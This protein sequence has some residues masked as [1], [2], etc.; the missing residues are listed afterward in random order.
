MKSKLLLVADFD[1]TIAK[2]FS[3]SPNGMNVRVAYDMA[4]KKVFG[5]PGFEY[6]HN[7]LGGLG[8]RE[9]GE[10]V[11]LLNSGLN[12]NSGD[13]KL[14]TQSLIDEKLAC[15]LSEITPEW[16]L[17]YPGV[18][19]FYKTSSE[20]GIPVTTAVVSSGHDAFV[21]KVFEVNNIP[22]P[23]IL[24]T[25]D[26]LL[27]RPEL[28]RPR[29]K[30]YTYQLAEAHRLWR[31]DL[32]DK[33]ITEAELTDRVA[34]DKSRMAY[35][36]DDP[37]KDGSLAANARI[38]FLYVPFTHPGFSPNPEK[39]QMMIPDFHELVALLTNNYKV[40]NGESFSSILFGRRDAEIFPPL[41]EGDRPVIKSLRE[42]RFRR[43]RE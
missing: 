37:N 27:E 28:D 39:G 1:G 21:K 20:G 26:L 14:L 9:P 43:E 23:D 12:G 29:Y 18:A 11:A 13:N 31:R 17:L 30:P 19:E 10:L 36:G 34:F 6:Y 33:V 32:Q 5:V 3:D 8:N 24:V 7:N 42:A 40:V 41:W 16:P 38:P 15:L 2:T 22:P 25:S 35:V 4:V